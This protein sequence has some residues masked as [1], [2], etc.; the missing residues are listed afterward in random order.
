MDKSIYLC[1]VMKIID[2]IGFEGLYKISSD[3]RVFRCA[4]RRKFG[5]YKTKEEP[6]CELKIGGNVNYPSVALVKNGRAITFTMHR[7]MAI[8]FIINDDPSTKDCVHHKNRN[9]FDFS[10]GNLEWV[11]R[12]QNIIYAKNKHL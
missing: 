11:S 8:H 3:G 9:I 10:L 6:E 12:G 4:R 7:L 1:G 2:V 5:K